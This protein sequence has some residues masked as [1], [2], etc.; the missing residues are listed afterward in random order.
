LR[1]RNLEGQKSNPALRRGRQNPRL[2]AFRDPV[3]LPVEARP[4]P[5]GRV[6][7]RLIA[8]LGFVFLRLSERKRI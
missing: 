5:F 3:S 1:Y 6:R 8:W 2:S 4:E 7:A